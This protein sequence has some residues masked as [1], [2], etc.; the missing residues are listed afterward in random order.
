MRRDMTASY[1]RLCLPFLVALMLKDGRIDPRRFTP[2]V[3]ADAELN[4]LASRVKVQPDDNTDPN[5][6]GP[7]SISVRQPGRE[8]NWATAHDTLGE[9]SWPMMQQDAAAKYGLA[10]E[11]AGEVSDIR[12]FDDPLAY[13]TEPR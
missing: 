10:R 12:I 8:P 3:F 13:F 4:E 6:L 2:D 7:Q 11:L 1:A 5:A 9:P